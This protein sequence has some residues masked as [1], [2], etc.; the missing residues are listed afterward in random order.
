MTFCKFSAHKA[1]YPDRFPITDS[2]RTLYPPLISIEDRY[3]ATS[4]HLQVYDG[5]IV[6]YLTKNISIKLPL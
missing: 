3:N 6:S 4:V 5:E 2:V 1:A